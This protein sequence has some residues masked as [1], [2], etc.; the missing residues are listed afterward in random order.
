MYFVLID[1]KFIIYRLFINLTRMFFLTK[2]SLYLKS[3]VLYLIIGQ[4]D[5]VI[6]NF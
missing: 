2:N 3:F 4:M 6:L 5:D 1:C